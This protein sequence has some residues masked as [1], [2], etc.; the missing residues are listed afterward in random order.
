MM[1]M[2][3]IY[4]QAILAKKRFEADQETEKEEQKKK[5]REMYGADKYMAKPDVRLLLGQT[6]NWVSGRGWSDDD[7]RPCMT[8]DTSSYLQIEYSKDGRVIKGAPKAV[9][10]SKYQEDIMNNN[11]QSVWGSFYD[12]RTGKWG[13]ACC[14]SIIKMSY[15]TGEEGRKANEQ[16][17]SAIGRYTRRELF[18]AGQ[19]GR[20][21]M[22][23]LYPSFLP[24]TSTQLRQHGQ[25]RWMRLMIRRSQRINSQLI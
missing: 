13:Y 12:K 14:H 19:S 2:L 5:I 1:M 20:L 4:I 18:V 6:E 25:R 11:H 22:L 17:I 10:R 23:L 7:E 15:C 24:T 9:V 16:H 3:C 21:M 8:A